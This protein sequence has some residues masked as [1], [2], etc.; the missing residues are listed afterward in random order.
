VTERPTFNDLF[1]ECSRSAIHLEMRDTYT[2][3]DPVFL[4]WQAGQDFDPVECFRGWYDLIVETVSRGVTVRRA[5]VVSEPITDFIRHEYEVAPRL[6][7]PAGELVRWLPRSRTSDLVFPGNDFWVFDDR[8]VRFG[9]FAGDGTYLKHEMVD[10][11]EI[12][13]TCVDAFEAV[14]ERAVDHADYKPT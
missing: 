8:L 10:D 9:H 11:P 6:N 3:E 1:S 12:V 4:A 7:I 14:W 13:K 2:P 5:R